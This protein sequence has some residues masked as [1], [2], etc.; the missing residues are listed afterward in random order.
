MDVSVDGRRSARAGGNRAERGARH[1]VRSV[2][3]TAGVACA[4]AALVAGVVPAASA[5]TTPAPDPVVV[6]DCFAQAQVRPEEYLLACGDGNNRLVDL[7]W[8]TWGS[9]TATA[10]GTD[11]VNDCRP[12]CAAGRFRAYPVTVTLAHPERWPDHPDLDRFT[13]LRIL[14][15]DKAPHPVP[16][17]STYRLTY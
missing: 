2:L 5:Q 13:T 14:Y 8:D 1:G 10:T 17:D 12:Y 3:R 4:A 15:T 6:V 9:R 7:H 11:M 16:K